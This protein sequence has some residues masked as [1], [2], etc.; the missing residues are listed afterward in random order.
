MADD[1]LRNRIKV[2]F[3]TAFG[4]D[5]WQY[6]ELI[7]NGESGFDPYV[8][9]QSSHACG[10]FQSLPC[11]KA[12]GQIYWDTQLNRYRLDPKSV[13]IDKHIQFGIDHIKNS[14]GTPANAYYKWLTR[15]PHWY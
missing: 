1:S 8:V 5:E 7:I 2:A 10:L 14:Y 4:E 12:G 3:V 13:D 11:E 6:A 9:N 15:S